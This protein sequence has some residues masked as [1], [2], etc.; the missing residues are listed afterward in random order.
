MIGLQLGLSRQFEICRNPE[1]QVKVNKNY[2]TKMSH[3][4]RQ[5]CYCNVLLNTHVVEHPMQN[6]DT[7]TPAP[8]QDAQLVDALN[9]VN[10][11]GSW[12]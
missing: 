4:S 6:G 12:C 9:G 11:F 7:S 10:S 5:L 1:E 8:S 3:Y 2:E